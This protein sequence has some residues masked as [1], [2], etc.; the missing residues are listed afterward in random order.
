MPEPT[1][2]LGLGVEEV[3]EAGG[4]VVKR[5]AATATEDEGSVSVTRG[6]RYHVNI[7]FFGGMKKRTYSGTTSGGSGYGYNSQGR[8]G[9]GG[10]CGCG[11]GENNKRG[12]T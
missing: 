7:I 5:V 4:M 9:G 10:G 11:C 1:V 12:T 8:A 3:E 6:Y 2:A